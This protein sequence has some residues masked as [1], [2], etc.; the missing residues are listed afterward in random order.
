MRPEGGGSR[1]EIPRKREKNLQ[2]KIC[3]LLGGYPPL[4][5]ERKQ[6][7]REGGGEPRGKI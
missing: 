5:E 3:N 1:G 6:K 2:K 4:R 7:K